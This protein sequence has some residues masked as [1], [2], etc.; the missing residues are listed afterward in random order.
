M[1]KRYAVTIVAVLVVIACTV[2]AFI[3]VETTGSATQEKEIAKIGDY[4]LTESTLRE[5]ALLSAFA[6]L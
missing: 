6:I 5:Y 1:T 2:F 4:S 3:N